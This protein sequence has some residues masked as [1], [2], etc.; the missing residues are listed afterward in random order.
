MYIKSCPRCGRMPKISEGRIRANGNRF[1]MIGCP[2]YC[3]VLRPQK[4]EDMW[5]S[6]VAWLSFEGT[7][8]Y[9]V[10]YKKWNEELIDD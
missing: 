7:Y 2:N 3:W 1:Y 8:D 9:N 6:G 5:R 10:M 4:Q